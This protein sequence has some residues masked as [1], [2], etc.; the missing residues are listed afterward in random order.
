MAKKNDLI[1]SYVTVFCGGSREEAGKR[2]NLTA[3]MIGHL[4]NG[5]RPVTPKVALKIHADTDGKISKARL[6]PDYWN[7]QEAA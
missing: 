7:E 6:R 3:G 2:L 1:C 4:M 5:I